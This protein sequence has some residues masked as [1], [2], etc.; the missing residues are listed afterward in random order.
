[1]QI[2]LFISF[3][4]IYYA[5][6]LHKFERND[7]TSIFH[8]SM[9]SLSVNLDVSHKNTST[10]FIMI[11]TK[12]QSFGCLTNACVPGSKCCGLNVLSPLFPCNAPKRIDENWWKSSWKKRIVTIWYIAT[13][14]FQSKAAGR[15]AAKKWPQLLSFHHIRFLGEKARPQSFS[16]GQS[17]WTIQLRFF[18]LV[19]S[20]LLLS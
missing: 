17:R 3:S 19:L 18:E 5:H 1:M 4:S 6:M 10:N 14:Y 11:K 12:L 16:Q 20:S 13:R 15:L 7:E 9:K 2:L 8:I